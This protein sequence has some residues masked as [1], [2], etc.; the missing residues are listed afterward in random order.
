MVTKTKQALGLKQVNPGR[1]NGK[2]QLETDPDPFRYGWRTVAE[3][4]PNGT[5]GYHN[6][7]LTQADFLNPQLGDHRVQS[8]QHL[9]LVI[10]LYNRFQ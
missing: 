7:P 10:S 2:Q 6:L 8:D 3:T 1:A 5:I 9:I 4:L